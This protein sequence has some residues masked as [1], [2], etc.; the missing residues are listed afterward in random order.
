M[1]RFLQIVVVLCAVLLQ[2]CDS[3]CARLD[4]EPLYTPRYAEGF[5]VVCH[6]ASGARL[7]HI[8]KPWQ[9]GGESSIY[10]AID[11]IPA[12]QFQGARVVTP[13]QRIVAMSSSYV[14]MLDA[15]GC[16]DRIVGISGRRFISTPAVREA[17]QRDEIAEVGHDANLDFE[18]IKALGCDLVL[19][20]GVSGENR[21][22]TR[23]LDTLGIPYIYIGD[24]VESEPLGKAEWVVAL[25]YLCGCP[26]RGIELFN[27]IEQRYVSIRD[28]RYCSA[29]KPRVMLNTPYRDTWFMPSTKSYMVRLIEDAGAEYVYPQNSGD[30]TVPISLEEALLLANKAD[31]WLNIGQITTMKELRAAV[32]RFAEVEAVRMGRVYNNNRRT[33]DCGGSDF[34]ESGTIRPDLVLQDLVR[35]LHYEAPTDSLYYYQRIE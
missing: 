22:V 3:G 13:V 26:E 11:P 15:I 23:K 30:A 31:F 32:P 33:T 21:G 24:Y 20:Y 8:T 35:I 7:L 10:V 19:L 18:Q 25:S 12:R 1:K 4:T 5:S 9:G 27:G 16:S 17:I 34:W 6:K 29:Y 14:A 2:A 28:K